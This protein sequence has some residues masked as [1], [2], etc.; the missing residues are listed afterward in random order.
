MAFGD[1]PFGLNAIRLISRTVTPVTVNLP[2]SRTMTF[3]PRMMGG[4]L[5]GSD[6][7]ASV[8][9]FIEALEWEI[10]EGG[11]P[12]DA[13]ALMTGFTATLSGT[14]PTQVNTLKLLTAKAMPYFKIF[15]KVLGEGI[16]DVHVKIF[17]AKLTNNID[18][19]FA[20]GEFYGL[21]LSGVAVADG[22]NGLVDIVQNE[23]AAALPSS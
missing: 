3:T 8:A 17:K 21:G 20:Y 14:T 18:G 16:D 5:K 19:Q 23:T 4:E 1:R 11:M 9:A 6:Q 7:L 12:L 15:G 22:A 2:V 13:L 10:D